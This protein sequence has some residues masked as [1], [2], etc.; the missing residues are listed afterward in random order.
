MRLLFSVMWS[1]INDVRNAILCVLQ[2]ELAAALESPEPEDSVS[3]A[4][5]A[6]GSTTEQAQPEGSE[7][8]GSSAGT[9][10]PSPPSQ[11]IKGAI[12]TGHCFEIHS[13]TLT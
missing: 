9:G 6:E 3:G 7:A 12:A 10:T 5:T 13:Y 8:G 1:Y 2:D 11:D 4:D